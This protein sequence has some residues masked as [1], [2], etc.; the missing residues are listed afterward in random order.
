LSQD[1]WLFLAKLYIRI[2]DENHKRVC[3]AD[4]ERQPVDD[5]S[6]RLRYGIVGEQWREDGHE[7]G[8]CPLDPVDEDYYDEPDNAALNNEPSQEGCLLFDADF[9]RDYLLASLVQVADYPQTD[10]QDA[11]DRH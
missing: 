9:R 10:C 11:Q 2:E 7:T 5:F 6:H 1:V 8:R 4:S 3:Q